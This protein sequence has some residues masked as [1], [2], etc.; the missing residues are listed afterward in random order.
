MR[1]L[2]L[3]DTF[4]NR[5]QPWRGPYNRRQFECLSKLCGVTV[6]DPIPWPRA[7]RDRRVRDLATG[8][9]SVLDGIAIYHPVFFYAP[10]I[11]RARTWRGLGSAA[12]RVLK[13][14]GGDRFD[15][16]VSTF[17]YPHGLAAKRLARE[18]GLPYVIKARGS[19]LHGLPATGARRERAADAVRDAAAVVA[20]APNLARIAR[21]LGAREE[22]V[23]VLTNGIDADNFRIEPREDA[24]R[25]LGLAP[26]RKVALFV[27]D[28][29]PVKGI[30]TLIGALADD[31]LSERRPL[32]AM[33]GEGPLRKTV[34]RQAKDL[35]IADRVRLLGRVGREEVSQWMNAADALV[36]SSRNEG[37]PNVVLEALACGT[38]VVASKVGAVPD[39]LDD[40]CGL[41]VPP[42]DAPA[43]ARALREALDRSW[44]R[45]EIRARVADRSW[46]KN[47]EA[48][49]RILQSVASKRPTH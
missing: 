17:A 42:R 18:M 23:H 22:N 16:I 11:G 24:R 38:P 33:A 39:L 36:L 43:L 10:V 5:L 48:F 26:D 28:L 27:G 15:A 49:Y 14:V 34:L 30:D 46:T 25:S 1:C 13:E 21:E 29:R 37:C 44:D 45:E 31:C 41:M 19:D 47:A 7:L 40:A 6:I 2:V 3:S 9:D 32:L 4:P 35:G 8:V 20:V 12:R